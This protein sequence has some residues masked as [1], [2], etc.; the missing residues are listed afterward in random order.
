MVLVLLF[1]L[2]FLI[3]GMNLFGGVM[4]TEFDSGDLNLGAHVFVELSID[5]WA[6]ERPM[7]MPGRRG[8]IIDVDP[9]M[10]ADAQWKVE[11]WKSQGLWKELKLVPCHEKD[12]SGTAEDKSGCVWASDVCTERRSSSAMI[13]GIVPRHNFDEF[14][15]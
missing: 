10:R 12:I 9:E 14:Y 11:V 3:L 8:V 13:T 1:I 15:M 7:S 2:I 5:P 6:K 4:T